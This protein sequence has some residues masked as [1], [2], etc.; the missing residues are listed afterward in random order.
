M[1][2]VLGI[3]PREYVLYL[4]FFLGFVAACLSIVP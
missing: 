1:E 4:S 3:N 2:V